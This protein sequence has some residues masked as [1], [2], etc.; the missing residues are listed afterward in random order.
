LWFLLDG[1]LQGVDFTVDGREVGI[2]FV[3]PGEC[4]GEMTVADNLPA[5][6]IVMSLTQSQVLLLP[7]DN[8]RKLLS[9]HP[10]V[11]EY[12]L[13]RLSGRIRAS[14]A[15]RTLIALPSPFQRVCAQLL[16]LA[17]AADASG[18]WVEHVPTHQEIAITINASRETVTRC[19]NSLQTRNLVRRD[20]V[21]L[22]LLDIAYLESI[23]DGR[24]ESPKI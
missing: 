7:T 20:G 4:F 12:I 24:L 17:G 2:Y 9:S 19:F 23:A 5:P 16:Q 15:Q 1:R 10:V 22:Q 13:Q 8:A 3:A 11:L 6:E 14:V 21:R 18:T